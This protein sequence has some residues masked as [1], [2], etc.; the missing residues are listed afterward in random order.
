MYKNTC[1]PLHCQHAEMCCHTYCTPVLYVVRIKTM[2]IIFLM[3][4]YILLY[5]GPTYHIPYNWKKTVRLI[6]TS[7]SHSEIIPNSNNSATDKL[8]CSSFLNL[9]EYPHKNQ[10]IAIFVMHKFELNLLS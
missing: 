10:G 5:G 3:K 4:I 6:K 9:I 2:G 1:Q 8:Y 7:G